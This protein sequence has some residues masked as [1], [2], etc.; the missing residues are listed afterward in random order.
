MA[1]EKTCKECGH[2]WG[3]HY[4]NDRC[5]GGWEYDEQ[6]LA[7]KDGCRCLLAHSRYSD[8]DLSQR[9]ETT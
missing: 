2:H 4:K 7:I 8:A 3:D 6:G 5:Y 9:R 1:D